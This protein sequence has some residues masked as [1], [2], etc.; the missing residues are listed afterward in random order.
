MGEEFLAKMKGFK[1]TVVIHS[2]ANG[3]NAAAA[4]CGMISA[5]SQEAGPYFSGQSRLKVLENRI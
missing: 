3:A 1:R 5:I 4:M 2:N